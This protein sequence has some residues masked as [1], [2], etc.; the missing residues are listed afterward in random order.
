M[1]KRAAG[2]ILTIQLDPRSRVP[3]HRQLYFR[4]R[5]GILSGDLQAGSRLPSSRSLAADLSVARNTVI[6]AITQ[7]RAE[8][9]VACRTGAGTR[10][11]ETIP[12]DLRRPVATSLSV[13]SKAVP[14]LTLS[15]R[16]RRLARL[17]G[18]T[19]PT[20]RRP[21]RPGAPALDRF[22]TDVWGQLT[23]RHLRH[24]TRE[25]LGVGDPLGH[26]PLREAV[27]EYLR[28]TRAVRCQPEQVIITGGSQET[29]YLVGQL[30]LDPGDEA[31]IEN[32]GYPGARSALSAS[33]ATVVPIPVDDQGLDVGAG[34]RRGTQPRMIYVTPSNQYPL[35]VTM[36]LTRRLELL[37]HARRHRSWIL[38]DDYDSEFRYSSRPMAALQGLDSDE[39]V[40]Y[41]GTFSRVLFPSLRLGYLV[42]PRSL[43]DALRVARGTISGRPSVISQAVLTDFLVEGHFER[44]V[45]R[46]RAV[47]LERL[48]VLRDAAAQ[49][50]TG[51]L[52]IAPSDAGVNVVGW[53]PKGSSEERVV[54]AA[55]AEGVQVASLGSF[56]TKPVPRQGVFLSYGP[57]DEREIRAGVLSLARALGQ[58]APR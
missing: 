29:L 11:V 14:G 48:G 9:Y 16:G 56:C 47:Y 54:R 58:L 45:R 46:M 50:L 52:D 41:A 49:H 44:H 31:W 5:E 23:S 55:A 32:P 12:Q 57:F 22:P 3:L 6:A 36:S 27:A 20:T 18:L 42:A 19:S 43:V 4:L 40:L 28:A 39:R 38:E 15:S 25:A 2:L 34:A 53:L 1:S 26:P 21:F 8:G 13:R 37:K 10:V 30:L 17:P 33:G 7:L 35:G 51:L 24:A